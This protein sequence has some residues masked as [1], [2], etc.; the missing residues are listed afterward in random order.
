MSMLGA[1]K[2]A[3]AL[4]LR[5]LQQPAADR[6]RSEPMPTLPIPLSRLPCLSSLSPLFLKIAFFAYELPF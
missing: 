2:M 5:R 4:R 3:V 1:A 6:K